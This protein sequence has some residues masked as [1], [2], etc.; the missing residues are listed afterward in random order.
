M[1]EKEFGL[2]GLATL[3]NVIVYLPLCDGM[4]NQVIK[5]IGE[6]LLKLSVRNGYDRVPGCEGYDTI[7]DC[8]LRGG[9]KEKR[10]EKRYQ[11]AFNPMWYL[12]ELEEYIADNHVKLYYDTRFC[13]VVKDDGVIKAV[14]VENKSGRS[15]IKCGAVVDA[16]GDADVCWHAGEK[17][18]SWRT[19][20]R[21]GWFYYFDGQQ[22]QLNKFSKWYDPNGKPMP[23]SGRGFAG[24]NADD[25]TEFV[26]ATRKLIK[27][28]LVKLKKVNPST[29]PL[30]MPSIPDFR[31]TRMLKGRVALDASHDKVW[32]DDAVGMTGDWRRKGPIFYIPLRSL[33]AVDT[34][35]LITAGRCMSS[36]TTGWDILRVIPTCA[37]TGE[38]A[39]GASAMLRKKKK[40]TFAELSIVEL[41][42]TLRSQNVLIDKKYA[43]TG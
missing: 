41:Q 24:D 43:V 4:G 8:W 14:V 32:F 15:A 39:G 13:G 36:G 25:V 29:S 26:L 37:V 23:K 22:V 28:E 9:D 35:N 21:A 5:G 6:E 30:F 1:I 33:T 38:A 40:S 3:G 18:V 34:G 12:L 2:G 31:M 42:K 17:T 19:N 7:P 11:V 27:K 20:V 10:G 16:S